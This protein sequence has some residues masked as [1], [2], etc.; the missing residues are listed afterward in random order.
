VALVHS[1]CNKPGATQVT[2]RYVRSGH[3]SVD[4]GSMSNSQAGSAGSIPVTRSKREYCYSRVQFEAFSSCGTRVFSPQPGH[5]G[6]H[7]STSALT[8]IYRRTLSLSRHVPRFSGSSNLTQVVSPPQLRARCER[9]QL[10][11]RKETRPVLPGSR[12]RVR[13]GDPRPVDHPHA[14]PR[15]GVQVL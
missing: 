10:R 2:H 3:G 11:R 5:F 4:R 15:R 8:F 9:A 6:P 14:T 13:R 12:R 7:N 1:A